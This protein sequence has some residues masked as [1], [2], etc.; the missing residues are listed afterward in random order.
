MGSLR[1][2]YGCQYRRSFV[3]APMVLRRFA[4]SVEPTSAVVTRNFFKQ[5]TQP[6]HEKI[7]PSIQVKK[8][9]IA[10]VSSKTE[11][12]ETL[13]Y[14]PYDCRV[15]THPFLDFLMESARSEL[16]PCCEHIQSS[17]FQCKCKQFFTYE[18]SINQLIVNRIKRAQKPNT[19]FQ[20]VL[21]FQ[22][23]FYSFG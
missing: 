8:H 3:L 4:T 14:T 21:L 7:H 11:V 12:V 10:I 18:T 20:A 6:V 17:E 13:D 16:P 9:L 22:H 1:T 15:W 23:N 5:K 19:L 2:I